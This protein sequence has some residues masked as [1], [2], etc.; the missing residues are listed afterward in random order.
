M[1]K[2]PTLNRIL[3][4]D[5]KEAPNWIDK[6]IYPINLFCETIYS[7]LNKN[8]TFQDNIASQ[9]KEVTFKTAST[10]VSNSDFEVVNFLNSLK[11]RAMGCQILQI[12]EV[13]GNY[14]PIKEPVSLDWTEVNGSINIH[15][16]SGLK[17]NTTY[18]LRILVI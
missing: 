14:I 4:E 15:F 13:T 11:T 8:I 17:D 3:K 1:A 5:I 6:V 18:N 10:Y 12:T 2:L 7:A 9:I 16:V